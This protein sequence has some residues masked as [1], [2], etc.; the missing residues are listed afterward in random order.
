VISDSASRFEITLK[1][2]ILS[3]LHDAGVGEP[4]SANRIAHEVSLDVEL[5][6]CQI[7]NRVTV[8]STRQSTHDD[9]SR[10]AAMLLLRRGNLL[11]NPGEQLT[12]LPFR[13]L[14]IGRFRRHQFLLELM[15][16]STPATKI[17]SK[18]VV[19]EQCFHVDPDFGMVC[20][21]AVHTELRGQ[22]TNLFA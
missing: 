13:R 10:L 14:S 9:V 12:S 18:V 19:G 17:R 11:L 15:G 7:E 22:L 6:A 2:R 8:L 21:M 5:N 1:R 3:E 16:D 4:G 20:L